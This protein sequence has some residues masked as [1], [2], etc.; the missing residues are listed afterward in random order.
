MADTWG[1]LLTASYGHGH[2]AAAEAIIEWCGKI[3]PDVRFELI[4]YFEE[5]VS[6]RVSRL[7]RFSYIQSVKRAPF[8]YGLF[9]GLT[10]RV[11]YDSRAQRWLNGLG[12]KTFAKWYKEKQPDIVACL[13]PT[14]AGAVS[15]LKAE[16]IV[17]CPSATII[18]DYVIHSQWVHP[19]CDLTMVGAPF[20]GDELRERGFP[21]ERV[22]VTGIPISTR[23]SD[24]PD[25]DEARRT[26]DIPLDVPVV[27]VMAGAF[28]MMRGLAE[29]LRVVRDTENVHAIFVC[30]HDERSK[31]AI[32]RKAAPLDGRVRV[33]GFSERIHEL[34]TLS[35]VCVTKA[36]GLTVSEA[37]ACGLPMIIH[38]PIP[39]QEDWN[40]RYVVSNGAA[41]AARGYR[42][43]RDILPEL[44]A[45]RESLM[46]M[47]GQSAKLGRPEAAKDVAEALIG[48]L[49]GKR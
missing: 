24:R 6:P 1:V 30:G 13:Y 31:R 9:Y 33:L 20:L 10:S 7:V 18:T 29:V 41:K 15:E 23:F 38:R 19:H 39:G 25:R 3:R 22:Q 11:K 35:D 27:L 5:F 21:P 46:E 28:G 16:G 26:W 8:L 12:K 34:M 44:V 43:L 40:M 14:P 45:S 17:E 36:G 37:T 32:E 48:L 49:D 42:D 4:D 2:N 47:R